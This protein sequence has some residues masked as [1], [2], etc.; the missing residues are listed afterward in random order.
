MYLHLVLMILM[1]N[2]VHFHENRTEIYGPT[3]R[4]NILHYVMV[5]VACPETTKVDEHSL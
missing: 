2:I 4:I 5:F 1:T 3:Y